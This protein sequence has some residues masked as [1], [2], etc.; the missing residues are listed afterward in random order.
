M[1]LTIRDGLLVGTTVLHFPEYAAWLP[2]LVSPL[3][4]GLYPIIRNVHCQPIIKTIA[5]ILELGREPR[6]AAHLLGYGYGLGVH[7]VNKLVRHGEIAY[8]IVVFMAIEI[9]AIIDECLAKAMTVIKHRRDAIETEAVEMK[10]LKPVLAVGQKEMDDVILAI[11]ETQAV[12]RRMLMPIAR[13]EILVRVACEVSQT[14][15]LVLHGM[16]VDYVHNHRD[17]LLVCRVN[18]GFKFFRSAEAARRSEE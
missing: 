6:H 7:L 10:L 16:R 1:T 11:V 18:E 9:I 4:D 17:A 14:L 13:I 8:R 15:Y 3:L 12:P 2:F 5:A